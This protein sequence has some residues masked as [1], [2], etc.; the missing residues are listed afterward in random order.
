MNHGSSDWIPASS[1]ILFASIVFTLTTYFTSTAL[2]EVV[3]PV[4]WLLIVLGFQFA[5]LLLGSS[6]VLTQLG[7]AS[8]SAL[9][10]V[11]A[12]IGA[13]FL[14]FPPILELR[15][16]GAVGGGTAFFFIMASFVAASRTDPVPSRAPETFPAPQPLSIENLEDDQTTELIK[17]GDVEVPES[18][19]TQDLPLTDILQSSTIDGEQPVASG[20]DIPLGLEDRDYEFDELSE[21]KLGVALGVEDSDS[22]PDPLDLDGES[23]MKMLDEALPP[24]S[25][26][27]SQSVPESDLSAEPVISDKRVEETARFMAYDVSGDTPGDMDATESVAEE[28]LEEKRA[29]LEGISGFKL[30]TRYKVLDEASGEH[31]GTYYGDEGYSTLDPVSLSALIG[32]K[33]TTGELRIVKLDWSNFDEVEVHIKIEEVIPIDLDPGVISDTGDR[34]AQSDVR[35]GPEIEAVTDPVKAPSED[36]LAGNTEKGEAVS[37]ANSSG[38]RYMIYDRRTIQ[39]MGEYIPKGDRSRIDR[40]T[41]YKMFP[42]YDFKTFEI[43]SIRWEA[44]EVRIFIRGEKKQSPKSNVQSPKK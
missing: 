43:D 30:R 38:R 29:A 5:T 10:A 24:G 22:L 44:D 7:A 39:P 28:G 20:T 27:G 33:L 35:G 32:S 19:D 21:T 36:V 1:L 12:C 13:V 2:W 18:I 34:G 16:M 31:Y 40:L 17:Y 11:V 9:I 23:V 25:T 42:E 4:Q 15:I 37:A 6:K 41:L 8:L 3:I 26:E 14:V